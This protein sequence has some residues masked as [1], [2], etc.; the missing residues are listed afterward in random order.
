[1][2]SLENQKSASE[3]SLKGV[4]KHILRHPLRTMISDWHWKAALFSAC[5]RTPVFLIAYHKQGL[6]VALAA[7]LVQFTFRTLF[8]GVGGSI[9]QKFSK[10]VPAWHAT[11]T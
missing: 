8:G 4:L 11:I 5:F 9:I 2:D 3:N 1:M 6:S 7:G 10:V